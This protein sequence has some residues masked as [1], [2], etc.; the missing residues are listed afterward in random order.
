MQVVAP[1]PLNGNDFGDEHRNARDGMDTMQH[2]RDLE[3]DRFGGTVV[4]T[5][6]EDVHHRVR[7]TCPVVVKRTSHP[8]KYST[9]HPGPLPIDMTMGLTF[10]EIASATL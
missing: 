8:N 6:G 9:S 10:L 7:G 3:L 5:Q 1:A 2:A 4:H